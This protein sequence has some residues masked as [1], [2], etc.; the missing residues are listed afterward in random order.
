MTFNPATLDKLPATAGVYLMKNDAGTVLYVG[1]AKDLRQRVKQ[2][3]VSGRDSRAMVPMLVQQVAAVDTIIVNSEREALLLEHTLIQQY[4][5]K[6]NVLLKD[7]KSYLAFKLERQQLWPR[8]QLVRYRGR[9][10]ISETYFGPYTSAPAAHRIYDLLKRLFPL[11]QCSDAEFARRTRPCLLY[12][13]KR[14]R[15]PCV[16]KCTPDEYH[17]DVSHTLAFLKG[18]TRYVLRDLRA[19]MHRYAEQLEF[20]R[21]ADILKSIRALEAHQQTQNVVL[22]QGVDLDAIALYRY[23]EEVV[24][25]QLFVRGGKV[26]GLRTYSFS[27]HVQEDDDL[28]SSFLLQQYQVSGDTS[29]EIALAQP[30]QACND[31][32]DLLSIKIY[33]PQRGQKRALVDMAMA[34]AKH[35]F[36]QSK[37]ESVQRQRVLLAMQ[38]ELHLA[39]YPGRIECFDNSHLGGANCV[40]SMVVYTDGVYDKKNRRTYKVSTAPGDDYGALR[41]TLLR[42]YTRAKAF[43]EFPDLLIVD[44]GKGHLKIALDVLVELNVVGVDVIAIAKEEGRHD[45]GG[46]QEQIFLPNIKDPRL[47]KRNSP[48]LFLLQQIRDDAH[49]VALRY[50]QQRRSKE[51]LH[52]A[53]DVIPGVGPVKRRALLVHFGS[54]KA[55][56]EATEAELM[57]VPGINAALAAI[58]HKHWTA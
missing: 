31:L 48:V 20:E 33:S 2:Y 39:H 18:D 32:S 14:C 35:A 22:L 40:S 29:I 36:H 10:P 21:A 11:R 58:I 9:P 52:S 47:L 3:F 49:R 54:V 27:H 41:A 51:L 28:L 42:R 8:L 19:E 37:D 25:C 55:I 15:A 43:E 45:K 12:G 53:V 13:L 4:R 30:L 26:T 24:V 44:G 17:R 1:K 46:T 6:Y 56:Q 38:E 34:N 5:P 7:D 16:G 23:G 57:Q 50:Q